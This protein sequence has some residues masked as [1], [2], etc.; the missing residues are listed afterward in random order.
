MTEWFSSID[1][2]E[3]TY[4][5]ITLIG[6]LFFVV[7]LF[8]TFLGGEVDDLGDMDFDGGIEFQ[9][10]SFKNIVGFVTIFG[11][12]GLAGIHSGWSNNL[13]II[14]SLIC[15]TVM[16][17]LM[18]ALFYFLRNSGESGTL[19]MKNAVGVVCEVYLPIGAKRSTIGKV[20]IKVQGSL[21]EL[22]ALTD[23]DFDLQ[24]GNVVKV[25]KLVTDELLLVELVKS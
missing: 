3:Q 25:V 12:T 17:A 13:T 11:W 8:S 9:F 20:Q 21:R 15:G 2:L 24:R 6:S 19:K 5:I 18:A 16:M 23:E 10:L 1:S 7:I 14:V 22:E 4:W